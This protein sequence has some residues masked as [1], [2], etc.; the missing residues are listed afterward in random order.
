MEINKTLLQYIENEILPRYEHFDAAHRRNHADDVIRRSMDL[1]SHYDVN[2]D[3]V[4]VIAAFHDTGLCEGRDTHHLASGRII[5]EDTFLKG[6]FTADEIETMAQAAEDHRA[7]KGSEPRSIYGKI[8][9]EADRLII[10]ETVIQRTIQFGLDHYPEYGK[11][12]QYQRFHQ[13]IMEKYADGGY[14]KLWLPE[15]ENAAKLEELRNI[16]R[17]EAQLREHF[18]TEYKKLKP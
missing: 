13:H 7:S 2:P 15:S 8:V 1:A 9:A 17:D 4:Y 14:L 10:P 18:E 16:I 11:E 5:R 3:M 12:G 6:H